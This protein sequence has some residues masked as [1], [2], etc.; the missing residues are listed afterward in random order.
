[1]RA[2]SLSLCV[3]VSATAFA[4]EPKLKGTV[5]QGAPK[6]DLGLPKFEAI[7]KGEG[8]QK[9][10]EKRATDESKAS[11]GAN[12][13][14]VI[15]VLHGKSFVKAAAGS[16]TATPFPGVM[17][18]GDPPTTEKFSSIVRVKCPEKRSANI[19]VIV[20]DMRED[21]V[22]EASG[23]LIFRGG[24]EAE[25]SVDWA[26]SGL[27]RKGDLSVLIR[28]SGNDVG[29]FPLKIV[30]PPP[31]AEKPGDKAPEKPPEKAL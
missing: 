31:P 4:T 16:K 8:L 6:L 13:Y 23:T 2:L 10:K 3:A 15:F 20:R 25:W 9:P 21:T 12:L 30:E 17:V 24:D 22:M 7:P 1:M 19:E 26:P 18:S 14:T 29:I 11:A 5:K 28:L 27:R